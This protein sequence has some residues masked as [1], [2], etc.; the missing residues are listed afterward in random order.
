MY[1]T[2]AKRAANGT[3]EAGGRRLRGLASEAILRRMR[4]EQGMGG[5][6]RTVRVE[7]P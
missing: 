3:P 2:V 5:N 7:N 4:I 6:M 1:D